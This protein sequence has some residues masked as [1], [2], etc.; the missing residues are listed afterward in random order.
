MPYLSLNS[1]FLCVTQNIARK[2]I[3]KAKEASNIV[4][5]SDFDKLLSSAGSI[6]G[7]TFEHI[8][9]RITLTDNANPSAALVIRVSFTFSP[10][11]ID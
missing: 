6:A 4:R 7:P 9:M 11:L 10:K 5:R 2:I 8:H 3:F 1:G